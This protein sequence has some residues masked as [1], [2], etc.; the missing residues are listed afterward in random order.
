MSITE[1]REALKKEIVVIGT[2]DTIKNIKIGKLEKIF[3]SSN[4]PKSIK[5]DILSYSKLS[6]I[7]VTTLK[8]SVSR[9]LVGRLIASV[10]LATATPEGVY[11]SSGSRVSLPIKKVLLYIIKKV[12][13]HASL[14]Q[15][16][17]RL[18]Q[19]VQACLLFGQSL[20]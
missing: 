6:K 10:N 4:C 15:R 3:L 11:L 17:L 18:R 7:P 1:I 8:K 20:R 5:A 2:K 12:R 9:S 16:P 13:R 14:E 19:L